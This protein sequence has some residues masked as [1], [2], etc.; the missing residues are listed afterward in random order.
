MRQPV[1]S[2]HRVSE[3]GKVSLVAANLP[4]YSLQWVRSMSTCGTFSVTLDCRMPV[5]WPG[6]YLVTVS[7]MREVGVLEKVDASE[8]GSASAPVLIGRF[9]ES[10]WAR[11]Q[12]G[13][14][15]E[16]ARGANWRQAITA[17]A[18]SWHMD[19][20]PGIVE[21]EGTEAAT[22]SSYALSG[23]SGDSAMDLIYSCATANGAY[24]ML[25]Y[26]RDSDPDHLTL[27]IVEGLDRTRAQSERPIAV[28]SVGLGSASEVSYSGDYSVAC[29]EVVAHAERDADGSAASVTRTVGVPGFDAAAQWKARAYE[30]VSS[31]VGQDVTPT[32]DLVDRAG[33]LRAYDHM[34]DL[35]I[36]AASAEAGYGERWDLGD[37]C[38]VEMASLG[39][40]ARERV[41]SV[42]ITVEPSGVTVVPTFGTKQISRTTR[43]VR[44]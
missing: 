43:A 17:A 32:N 40:V 28:F 8:S 42:T 7:G 21:G 37:L 9:V 41:E 44:R 2:L 20:V 18:L 5:D 23:D 26:D 14:G 27:S 12:L 1:L 38:E 29:S 30:D 4:V 35:V 11:Y 3:S 33:L 34:P 31:L 13:P 39:L 24:P 36:D 6:R 19:D 10:V 25:S 16:S 22:G 15:G